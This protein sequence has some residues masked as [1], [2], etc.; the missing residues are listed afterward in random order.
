MTD[1]V[2]MDIKDLIE[3]IL[4]STSPVINS[5][6]TF[7]LEDTNA[8]GAEYVVDCRGERVG[9]CDYHGLSFE[10]YETFCVDDAVT[11]LFDC[12]IHLWEL[13]SCDI[14]TT[15]YDAVGRYWTIKL[16]R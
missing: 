3:S 12:D 11:F 10:T 7:I 13:V 8:K 1:E 4:E 5:C 9:P 14:D 2:T 15:I 6:F 16:K